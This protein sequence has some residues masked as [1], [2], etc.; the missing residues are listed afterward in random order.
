[1]STS[2]QHVHEIFLLNLDNSSGSQLNCWSVD[3]LIVFLERRK[4]CQEHRR[5]PRRGYEI[6]NKSDICWI[7]FLWWTFHYIIVPTMASLLSRPANIIFLTV[8]RL[9]NNCDRARRA[10]SD[11]ATESKIKSSFI[12]LLLLNVPHFC[13]FC[14]H[15]SKLATTLGEFIHSL[16]WS[17]SYR[18]R[19]SGWL[20]VANEIKKSEWMKMKTESEKS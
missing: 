7:I 6:P 9:A 5:C 4:L 16:T 1:M 17:E 11:D 20:V 18:A 12:Q 3:E 15:S 13:L 10:S 19:D 8:K 2:C 14:W